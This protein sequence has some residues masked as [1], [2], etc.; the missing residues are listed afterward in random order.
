MNRN[1]LNQREIELIRE[2]CHQVDLLVTQDPGNAD[3]EVLERDR[4]KMNDLLYKERYRDAEYLACAISLKH[5]GL[6]A[7]RYLQDESC[8]Q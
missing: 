7:E 1:D 5:A 8:D 3:L 2:V 4:L 6:Q